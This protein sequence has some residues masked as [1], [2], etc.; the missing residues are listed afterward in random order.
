MH[1]R[2]AHGNRPAGG[3][4]QQQQGQLCNYKGFSSSEK[5]VMFPASSL[6][7]IKPTLRRQAWRWV[8]AA[9]EDTIQKGRDRPSHE[10]RH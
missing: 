10:P 7:R 5:L 3:L 9:N 2:S 6:G 4:A 1:H 8:M